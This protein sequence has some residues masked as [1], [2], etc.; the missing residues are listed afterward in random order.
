MASRQ[1]ILKAVLIGLFIGL[2]FTILIYHLGKGTKSP[3]INETS[4]SPSPNI[5]I[6]EDEKRKAEDVKTK[7]EERLKQANQEKQNQTDQSQEEEEYA[8]EVMEIT[9]FVGDALEKFGTFLTEEPNPLLWNNEERVFLAGQTIIIEGTYKQAKEL[10][11]PERFKKTHTLLLASL[12]KFSQSMPLFRQGAD[13]LDVDK[14]N[15]AVALM[16]EGESLMKEASKQ[17]LEDSL[18]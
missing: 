16:E 8:K 7:I 9:D 10:N 18:E 13:D 2:C 1:K 5:Q 11:P 6:D 4:P 12:E 15:E 17:I 14:I 3:D